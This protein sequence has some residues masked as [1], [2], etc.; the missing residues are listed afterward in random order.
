MPSKP[1]TEMSSG[2]RSPRSWRA[3]TAPMACTSDMAKTAVREG[4]LS[5]SRPMAW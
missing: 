4:I 3:R 1:M 5:K 2:T